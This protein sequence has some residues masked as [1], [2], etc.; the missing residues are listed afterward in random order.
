MNR[1]EPVAEEVRKRFVAEE[2]QRF[3]YEPV[4]SL[5]HF[6][7]ARIVFTAARATVLAEVASMNLITVSMT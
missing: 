3:D 2:V 7:Y 4:E 5:V 6:G 1:T